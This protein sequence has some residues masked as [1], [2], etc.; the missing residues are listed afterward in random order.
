[1]ALAI[2][3]AATQ[4]DA[5]LFCYN[6]SNNI[7]MEW[8]Q[9]KFLYTEQVG[10][11]L[12]S[13][14][15]PGPQLQVDVAFNPVYCWADGPEL[16]YLAENLPDLRYPAITTSKKGVVTVRPSLQNG[17][18]AYFTGDDALYIINNL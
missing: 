1:V 2:C 7:G 6:S 17:A 12:L 3:T 11:I 16:T 13:V 5:V 4:A 10:D 15:N 14:P 9:G 8:S 18:I